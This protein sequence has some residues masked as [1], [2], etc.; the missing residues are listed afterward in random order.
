MVE[1]QSDKVTWLLK[2]G[3]HDT[4]CNDI[5]HNDTQNDET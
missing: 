3:R 5:Q 4:H 1:C 2:P